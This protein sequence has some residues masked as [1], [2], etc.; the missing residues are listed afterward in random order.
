MKK[1]VDNLPEILATFFCM[2]LIGAILFLGGYMVYDVWTMGDTHEVSIHDAQ[3]IE[4]WAVEHP[5]IRPDIQE[6]YEN[7]W[8][9][10]NEYKALSTKVKRLIR[11][12]IRSKALSHPVEDEWEFLE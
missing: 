1:F 4:D 5:E 3:N 2:V 6:A 8:V 7:G 10:L 12:K 9:S 11:D